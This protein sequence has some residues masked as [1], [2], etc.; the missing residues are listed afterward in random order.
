MFKG[1]SNIPASKERK[2]LLLISHSQVSVNASRGRTLSIIMLV[3]TLFEMSMS[4]KGALESRSEPDLTLF[5]P[6]FHASA[7]MLGREV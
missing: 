6:S 1:P 4:I 7:G 5:P 2:G 3:C